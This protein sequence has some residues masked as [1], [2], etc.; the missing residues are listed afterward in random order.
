MY[1]NQAN[2]SEFRKLDWV[3]DSFQLE[4][5]CTNKL[6]M[7][8]IGLTPVQF[9]NHHKLT[10]LEVYPLPERAYYFHD[11]IDRALYDPK[12]KLNREGMGF[13]YMDTRRDGLPAKYRNLSSEELIGR[14]QFGIMV[15]VLLY[16]LIFS[17]ENLV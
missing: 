1:G 3:L 4:E 9:T 6:K 10:R 5:F 15:T 12:I 7:S 11:G 17:L 14:F 16:S 13:L 8:S 2:D